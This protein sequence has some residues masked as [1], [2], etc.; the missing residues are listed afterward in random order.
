MAKPSTVRSWADLCALAEECSKQDWLFRGEP[1]DGE[2][3][4]PKAG[5]VGP[6]V[7]SPR[8]VAY[9]QN[10]EKEALAEFRRRAR[11]YLSHTPASDLEWLSI[12]QHY[13]LPTRLLD[14]TENLFVAAFF[15]VE[16]AG[17]K[18]NAVIYG[19]KDFRT[20]DEPEEGD[21]FTIKTPGAY[22]PPHITPRIPTQASVFTIHPD[23]T[24]VFDPPNLRKWVLSHAACTGIKQVLDSC[25]INEGSL[26]P[27]VVGLSRYL[28]WLYKWGKF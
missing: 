23:P 25:A 17:T 20:L 16:K 1:A 26:F 24:M 2:P 6:Q 28:A 19:L 4:K 3:L 21:P 27:D 5:R 8:K 9:R 15:A 14:W 22:F 18:G 13:G 10:D 12:A 11:P 7:G